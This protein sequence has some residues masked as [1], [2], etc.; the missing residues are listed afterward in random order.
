MAVRHHDIA[1]GCLTTLFLAE[2]RHAAKEAKGKDSAL[3]LFRWWCI[4]F[5]TVV[6]VALVSCFVGVYCQLIP[7]GP[8]EEGASTI[9]ATLLPMERV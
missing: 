5:L 7:S 9:P 1:L 2:K 8:D 6:F 4:G 3:H